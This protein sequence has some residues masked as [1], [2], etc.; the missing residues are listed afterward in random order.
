MQVLTQVFLMVVSEYVCNLWD[1]WWHAVRCCCNVVKKK[2]DDGRWRLIFKYEVCIRAENCNLLFVVC[3]FLA[4]MTVLKFDQLSPMLCPCYTATR[5]RWFKVFG[6]R[7]VFIKTAYYNEPYCKGL[8]RS[9]SAA[10]VERIKCFLFFVLCVVATTYN[11]SLIIIQ[12]L[13][14]E[15][16]QGGLDG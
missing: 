4:R 2:N 8:F 15:C 5:I 6:H 1:G 13:R 7:C 12:V 3:V 10:A 9:S 11:K 14:S 16:R